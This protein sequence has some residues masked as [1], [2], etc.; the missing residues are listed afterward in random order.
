MTKEQLYEL[1]GSV[2]EKY[3]IEAECGHMKKKRKVSWGS[4]AACLV[5][6]AVGVSVGFPRVFHDKAVVVE[7]SV[8]SVADGEK[9]SQDFAENHVSMSQIYMNQLPEAT[10]GKE[11][12]IDWDPKIY[13]D[14][15]LYDKAVWGKKEIMEYYGADLTPVYIPENLTASSRNER[16]VIY[17][18]KEGNIVEDLLWL[19]FY[20][21]YY[22]DGSPKLTENIAA[23]KGVSVR[24]SKI[25]IQNDGYLLMPE[26]ET[27]TSNIHG[28]EV[29]F[30]YRKMPYGPYDPDTHEPSGYYDPVSYTHLY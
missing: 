25:D 8:E 7:D 29:I 11:A 3:L 1:L 19:G 21:D 22:E 20:H 14:P 26:N 23:N 12:A 18:D 24:A 5:V 16:M 6:A 4:L 2:D 15:K 9:Q 28:T 30:G 17:K 10:A 27:E 13:Y